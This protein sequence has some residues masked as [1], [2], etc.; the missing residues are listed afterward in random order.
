MKSIFG[1]ENVTITE[2]LTAHRKRRLINATK[3]AKKDLNF[4][5]LSTS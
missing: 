5:F 1:P 3:L 2:N 4:Q